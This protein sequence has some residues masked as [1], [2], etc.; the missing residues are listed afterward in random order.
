LDVAKARR[1]LGPAARWLERIAGRNVSLAMACFRGR[2]GTDTIITDGEHVGIPL[3]LL[4][5]VFGRGPRHTRHVMIAHRLSTGKK[6]VFLDWL[7]VQ[8]HVDVFL[9]YASAQKHFIEG[10]WRLATER[11]VLI[12]F[13]VDTDFY[14]SAAAQGVTTK[15]IER[16]GSEPV[17]CAVGLER[18][19][20]RT[21]I[22]AVKGLPVRVFIT[23]SSAWSRQANTVAEEALPENV[24]VRSLSYAGLRELYADSAFMV[25]PLEDVD[26]QAG[27]TAILEAMAMERAVICSRASGQSDV[28][29]EG[30]TGVYVPVGDVQALRNAIERLLAAPDDARRMGRNGRALVERAMSLA[31]YP[32]FIRHAAR[33]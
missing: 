24:T 26:F 16:S 2:S 6:M 3:A 21:L 14:S 8:S 20:Y 32:G 22:E 11:V 27:V 1:S 28:V 10:R 4:L 25:M 30:E 31:L 33:I 17:I 13:Q 29:K 23:A 18:R 15:E 9:V 5:K 19:D 7:G 12:P